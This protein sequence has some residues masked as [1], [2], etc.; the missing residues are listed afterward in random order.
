MT[1]IGRKGRYWAALAALLI[2]AVLSACG[3]DSG[4][5]QDPGSAASAP[6]FE[7]MIEAAP[8]KL[9]QLYRGEGAGGVLGGGAEALDRRIAELR[10]TPIV[11]NKWASWCQPC[12]EEFPQLQ[13]QAAERGDEV[14][15]IGINSLDNDDAAETFLRDHPLPYPSYS[16]PDEEIAS[17]FNA[18]NLPETIFLDRDGDV[19]HVKT[20]PYVD[21][22]ELGADIDRY[23]LRGN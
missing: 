23:A 18:N 16:D 10:G 17:S 11:L 8:P 5:E 19:T 20:G 1:T 13:A 6:D 22:A 7:V 3:S 12:R 15:F 14:A 4:G 21:E 9:Q 2:V